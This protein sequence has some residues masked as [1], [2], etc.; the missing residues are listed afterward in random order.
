M[1]AAWTGSPAGGA[2]FGNRL[3]LGFDFLVNSQADR[4]EGGGAKAA[5]RYKVTDGFSP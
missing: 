1:P 3:D 5:I 4:S 2:A